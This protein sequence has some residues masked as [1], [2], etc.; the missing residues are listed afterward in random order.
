MYLR[1]TAILA[2]AA[3]LCSVLADGPVYGGQ[4]NVASSAPA[5]GGNLLTQTVYGFLDFTTTIGNTVMVFSPQS[6]P[7]PEPPKTE[8][9]VQENIIE[10][11]PPPP[12]VTS[13]KPEAIKPSKISDKD[14][15]NKPAAPAVLSSA[16]SVVSSPPKKDNKVPNVPKSAAKDQKQIITKVEVV[17]GP[18]KTIENSSQKQSSPKPKNTQSN[19]N[20]KN[21]GVK[22]VTNVV[23]SK[24]EV[25]QNPSIIS[26]KVNSVVQVKSSRVEEEPAI[27][28]TN[29]NI[30]EPEYDFLSRQPSEFVEET[31]KVINIRPSKAPGQKPKHG[32][33]NR[34][35][36]TPAPDDDEDH[37]LG[38]VTT[39]GGTIVKDGLT[40]VHET[41][42]I[43]TFISGKYAQVL[44]SNSKIL[45]QAGHRG[46]ISPTP[47]HRILKT[48]GPS[49][50]KNTH[51][52][53]E[54]TPSISDD[55]SNFAKSTRRQ[56]NGGGSFKN[57]HRTQ[58][59]SNPEP[60]NHNN[61]PPPAQGKKFKNR[62]NNSQR[63]QST[64]FGR[65]VNTPQLATVSVFSETASPSFS[66][67]RKSNR[68]SGHKT[69]VT[70]S[71]NNDN[72]SKRGFK[73][74]V[75]PT[76]VEQV[77]PAASTSVYKF[78]LNR[79]PGSGRW[80]YKTSPKPKVTIRKL[81]ADDEQQTTPNPNPLLDDTQTNDISLQARSD[82]DLELSGSQ[83]GPG[84]LLENDTE[85]NSIEKPPPVETLKV[86]ISTP[87]DFRDVYYEIATIR[88]PYTFQVGRVKNTR[89]ITVTS[90]IEKRIEPTLAVNSQSSL[91][92]PLTENILATASPYEKDHYLDS[93]IVTLPAITLSSDMETPPLETV[94]ETFS[95]TQNMLKTHI[96]PVVRDVN[97]TSSLTF[98]QTYQVTRLVTATK[99]LPP[100]DFF[101][102][103][104]SKTLKEFNSRLDEAG[105]ELHLELDFG[106]SN[107]DEEGVPR[108]VFPADLD[109]ASIGSDFDLTEV[110]KYRIQ[111]NHLRLKKAHGQNKGNHV[112]ES[113][114]P[115]TPA[116]TP[117]QA[118]QL[119][120]LRLLNPAAAAQIP[121]VVTT[122]KPIL[123]YET[124]YES[125][126]IPVF[127]GKTTIQSTISRPVATITK[128]EYEIGTSSLPALPLQTINPLF[129]QQFSITSTPV[130][131]NTE[132]TATNS[133]I[134]KLTFGA[135][136]VY[137]TLFTTQVVPTV[138]TSYVTSSVAVQP[139]AAPPGYPG[140]YPAPFAPFPYVG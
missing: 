111:D 19:K 40:T 67:R 31:Y 13:V 129:P 21:E 27:L 75:Q 84:T 61:N 115:P 93:S 38:L 113:P 66:N 82:N 14:K 25:K 103:I 128:T 132:V 52:H 90:T 78:K 140:Y 119:A 134:L 99:T 59:N 106:D 24:V 33:K 49:I 79:A 81:N 109:L 101:Q 122:S 34:H 125:H 35:Q 26:S 1:L 62:N 54:P 94:T 89:I 2:F 37:P 124:I 48:V 72:Q 120:L 65:P 51:R 3:H 107:E 135:K 30:G 36:P 97:M 46:K 116:L 86:E 80:Q 44:N 10:T 110:D 68:N 60:E 112:T 123:K 114:N 42:V 73:P 56:N 55:D 50:S 108:R 8:K 74:R 130:V 98:V 92:E 41:S 77:T 136:T 58:Q 104:P 88:S 18:S 45:P 11:K 87:A 121:D 15:T 39:L 5:G 85:D 70:P 28:I 76:P 91:N 63:T 127:D 29:N 23:S 16:V 17:A 9:S 69:T 53:L 139:S 133:Q 137:T 117:E 100:M 32:H 95:T 102:F 126:V 6:A 57:R 83:S 7:P 22:S 4:P 47:T 131:V 71:S 118:Q 64:R 20:K 96:L 43:G 12:S 138:M 105:S